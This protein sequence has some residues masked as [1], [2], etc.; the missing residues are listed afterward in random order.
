M[1]TQKPCD[2][3]HRNAALK[4]WTTLA[5]HRAGRLLLAHRC[6]ALDWYQARGL[7]IIVRH[8]SEPH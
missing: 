8:L 5:S 4:L 1:R 6:S 7:V 3:G 2:Q